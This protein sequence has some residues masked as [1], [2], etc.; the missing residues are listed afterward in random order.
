MENLENNTPTV[1]TQPIEQVEKS[2]IEISK[3]NAEEVLASFGEKAQTADKNIES[4]GGV[5]HA[6]DAIESA[7]A[8]KKATLEA[9]IDKLE[10]I[11][12]ASDKRASL[13]GKDGFVNAIENMKQTLYYNLI[14]GY[15]KRKLE[16]LESK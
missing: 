5:E 11:I 6:S 15:K 14:L 2:S 4:V 7:A 12:V 10:K 16:K 9:D 13:D 1:E 3:D 8:D